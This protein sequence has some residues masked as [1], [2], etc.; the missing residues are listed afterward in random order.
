M[1]FL[2][3]GFVVAKRLK[4][5]RK[6]WAADANHFH[7]RMARIGFSQ[8]KTV[9]YLYAWTLLLAG[10]AVALRFVPYHHDH[11]GHFS[12]GWSLVMIAIALIAVASQ[13][14]LI[15]VLE[16]LKFREPARAAR[17]EQPTPDTSEHEIEERV[18]QRRRDRRIRTGGVVTTLAK[19]H[20]FPT[21]G[22]S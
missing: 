19:G 13:R 17:C 18:A 1:P 2:D 21:R 6:P 15:Y 20:E 9:A 10:V 7:H 11:P 22:T 3:T 14:L 4:Y 12:L 5:R 8:R 16:I